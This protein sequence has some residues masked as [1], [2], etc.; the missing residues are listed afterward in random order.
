MEA[1]SI[2]RSKNH[3]KGKETDDHKKLEE[4][5]KRQEN[6]ERR[7]GVVEKQV[8]VIQRKVNQ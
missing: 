8:R 3:T 6:T 5:K 7:L 4:V 1:I 2:L